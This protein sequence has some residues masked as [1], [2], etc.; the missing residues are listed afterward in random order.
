M[1][2]LTFMLTQNAARYQHIYRSLPP[3]FKGD[4]PRPFR[5]NLP[6]PRLQ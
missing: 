2:T 3:K 4:S 6:Q 1:Y 5:Y